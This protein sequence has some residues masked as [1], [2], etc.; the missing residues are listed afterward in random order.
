MDKN[1][2]SEALRRCV[3]DHE[4]NSHMLMP[5]WA[6]YALVASSTLKSSG[7]WGPYVIVATLSLLVESQEHFQVL[8]LCL[9][10]IALGFVMMVMVTFLATKNMAED[11]FLDMYLSFLYSNTGFGRWLSKRFGTVTAE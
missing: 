6:S 7:F 2:T 11:G 1:L 5:R 3:E 10:V 8:Y 4:T 9:S